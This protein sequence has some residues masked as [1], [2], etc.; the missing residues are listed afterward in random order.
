MRFNG[1]KIKKKET[2]ESVIKGN[3]PGPGYYYPD[4]QYE[5]N[6]KKMYRFNY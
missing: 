1:K 3:F 2:F 5:T 6:K 4:T